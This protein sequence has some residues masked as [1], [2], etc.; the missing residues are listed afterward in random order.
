MT[1]ASPSSPAAGAA[2]RARASGLLA[3]LYR[4]VWA[5]VAIVILLLVLSGAILGPLLLSES[6]T[7]MNLSMRN[8]PPFTLSSGFLYVLGGDTL[9]RPVLA[10][11]LYASQTTLMI[12]GT[13]VALSLTFGTILGLIA[14]Y[15]ERTA[16]LMIMRFA[17][18]I[19]S[20]PT[21]LLAIVLLYVLQ[22]GS[23][24]VIAV[25]ALSRM[26]LYIRTVRAEVLE[27]RQRLFVVAARALGASSIRIILRHI[28]PVVG[29]TLL[30]LATLEFA[31]V[32]LA[33]SSL[34]FLGLGVQSPTTTW[35]LMVAEGR[36]YLTSAWWLSFW[37]GLCIVLV[38]MS[39]TVLS[40][41]IRLVADPRQR[42]RLEGP[43]AKPAGGRR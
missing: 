25:L 1:G 29:P 38:T 5:L 2:L 8:A 13:A 24:T 26:P 17:D 42:W 40:N 34:T 32:M 39:L 27:V 10:R 16:G 28:L 15:Y 3:M 12:T 41:W 33:E 6:A 7:R 22:P 9:G 18:L 37:P 23:G 20:F 4:D 21:L 19:L 36:S 30:I 14:G 35:G 31:L 43:G 11:V